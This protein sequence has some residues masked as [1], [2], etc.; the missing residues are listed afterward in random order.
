VQAMRRPIRALCI[1]CYASGMKLA[2]LVDA[3]Q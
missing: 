1:L 2:S 3:R